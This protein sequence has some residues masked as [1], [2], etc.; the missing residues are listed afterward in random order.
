MKECYEVECDD[1]EVKRVLIVNALSVNEKSGDES[2][3][4]RLESRISNWYRCIRVLATIQRFITL[5]KRKVYKKRE[6]TAHKNENINQVPV[7]Q[8]QRKNLLK[9]ESINW[10]LV[11][12]F[13]I[14][15]LKEAEN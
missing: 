5:C 14:M 4:D 11:N 10:A 1:P 6:E 8:K 12:L 7:N 9:T 13:S 3:F 15:D 2:L